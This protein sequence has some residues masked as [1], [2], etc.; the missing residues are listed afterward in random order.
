MM[1]GLVG[2]VFL[3]VLW[4]A[5]GP[6]TPFYDWVVDVLGLAAF[7]GL[8]WNVYRTSGLH[9]DPPLGIEAMGWSDYPGGQRHS[10]QCPHC[11][12]SID[13]TRRE[14]PFGPT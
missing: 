6:R 5:F 14:S 13:Q 1:F 8:L 9:C 2:F 7:A 3:D 11:H 4:R 12:T 10:P